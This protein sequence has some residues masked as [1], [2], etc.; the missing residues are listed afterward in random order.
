[1][2]QTE[3]QKQI[4]PIRQ[5][6]NTE[7]RFIN[8]KNP[9]SP[10]ENGVLSQWKGAIPFQKSLELQEELKPL[11]KKNP[12]FFLG[13]ESRQ[14]VITKGLGTEEEDILWSD[15]Q[16][17]EKQI[18][19]MSLK[20]G[21]RA[22]LHAP[23]QLVIYPVIHLASFKWQIKDFILLLESITKEFLL[24]LGITSER[25]EKYSGLSTSKGKIAFFGIHVSEGVSQ[26]G[27]SIN[28]SNDLG[29]F[30]SIRSC[31]IKDRPHDRLI[32]HQ[33]PFSIKELFEKWTDQAK[34]IFHPLY[35]N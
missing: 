30:H 26:H 33:I 16:L 11:A 20:R 25:K 9:Q 15:K 7:I 18:N 19:V 5:T 22:T 28:V 34:P 23:G 8:K 17:K 32:D 24:D 21:G 29:L 12:G 2:K 14:G 13:F 31:G 27:L 4:N 6:H 10:R 1:M 3:K 35:H